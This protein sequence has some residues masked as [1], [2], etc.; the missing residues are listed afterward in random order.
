MNCPKCQQTMRA[1]AHEGI[2]L[3]RC[4]ACGGL[5]FDSGE[6]EAILGRLAG[7]R[8]DRSPMPA[9]GAMDAQAASCPRCE[10]P[11]VAEPGPR[12]DLHIDRCGTCG[13]VFLDAGELG[14]L[15]LWATLSGQMP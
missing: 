1:E 2:E 10:K 7:Q 6:L 13:G 8:L 9:N 14:T 4:G 15:Q 3:D 12:N 11:M 5:F